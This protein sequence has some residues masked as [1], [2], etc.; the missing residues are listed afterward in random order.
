MAS[1][2]LQRCNPFGDYGDDLPEK[3]FILISRTIISVPELVDDIVFSPY[4]SGNND[5]LNFA[6]FLFKNRDYDR[7]ITEYLRFVHLNPNSPD[8]DYALYRIGLCYFQKQEYIKALEI[9]NSLSTSFDDEIVIRSE[10]MMGKIYLSINEFL[11]ARKK[12]YNALCLT[13]DQNLKSKVQLLYAWTFVEEKNWEQASKQFKR[14]SEISP[15]SKENHLAT[16]LSEKVLKGKDIPKK[17]LALGGI[18]SIIPGLGK[19]YAGRISDGLV[20][21]FLIS[22]LGYLTYDTYIKKAYTSTII[23]SLWFISFYAGNIYG[24]IDAVRNYNAQKEENFI[25]ELK[26]Q[27][28]IIAE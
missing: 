2:R 27:C 9:F 7:A 5:I 8:K 28:E 26:K 21:F 12:F 25:E 13:E 1:D 14:V 10:I 3:H 18:L 19:I 15:D 22:G 6:E 24:G 11:L 17:S 4:K 16:D 20:S 23:W